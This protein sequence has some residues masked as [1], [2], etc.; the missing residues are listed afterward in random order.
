MKIP[1]IYLQTQVLKK[2]TPKTK[3]IIPVHYGGQSCDM[4]ALMEIAKDYKI[5]IR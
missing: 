1:S 4:K 3:A 5:S 2:I